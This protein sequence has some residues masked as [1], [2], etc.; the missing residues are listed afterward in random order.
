[1]LYFLF[2]R[3]RQLLVSHRALSSTHR[4]IVLPSLVSFI[5]SPPRPDALHRDLGLYD[6]IR[7]KDSNQST[8]IIRSMSQNTNKIQTDKSVTH[9]T[10]IVTRL[11]EKG[12]SDSAACIVCSPGVSVRRAV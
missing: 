6:L 4:F 8:T 2:T 7:P 11:E 12:A 5:P 9:W 1:M 3:S 10:K